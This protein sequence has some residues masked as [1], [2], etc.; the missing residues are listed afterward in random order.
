MAYLY[1]FENKH[2]IWHSDRLLLLQFDFDIKIPM[3]L[4]QAAP[5]IENS[6]SNNLKFGST[7]KFPAMMFSLH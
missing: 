5:S 1:T 4:L 7:R 3:T 6:G 2:H